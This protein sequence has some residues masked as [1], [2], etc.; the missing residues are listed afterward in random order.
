M[1]EL[2][3]T[4][5]ATLHRAG[6][7]A[8]NLSTSSPESRGIITSR[9]TRSGGDSVKAFTASTPSDAVRT[10]KPAGSSLLGVELQDQRVIV[11]QEDLFHVGNIAIS[12]GL[13]RGGIR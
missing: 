4:T 13:P 11:H 10:A 7:E 5:T 9:I 3:N 2:V 12:P 1:K 8:M 6:F